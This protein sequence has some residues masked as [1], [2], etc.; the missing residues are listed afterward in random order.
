[1][2]NTPTTTYHYTK[3]SCAELILTSNTTREHP[4]HAHVHHWIIA[5]VCSGAVS[6]STRDASRELFQG[7]SFIVPPNVTHSLTVDAEAKLAILCL[8]FEEGIWKNIGDMVDAL[9]YASGEY[10]WEGDFSPSNISKLQTLAK[11]LVTLGAKHGAEQSGFD[12]HKTVL[13]PP[14]QAV[15]RVLQ[16]SP[17]ESYTL[18]DMADIA[19]YSRW[20]FLRL[21]QKE[22]GLTPH[23]YLMLCRLRRLRSLLRA[24]TAAAAA[25]VSAGFSDQSH[26]HRVFKL[27]H[28]LTPKQFR[29]ASI[30]L[31]S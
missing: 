28:G 16:E 9:C 11:H 29:E 21:F 18:D 5:M 15:V 27:H 1:M 4:W 6:F 20:H 31:E 19:R 7:D 23:A 25:A 13:T 22:L 12:C 3:S 8:N 2:R 30:S 24:D 17:E 14:V 26:M 10:F